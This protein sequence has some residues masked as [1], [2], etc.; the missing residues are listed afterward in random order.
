M[1]IEVLPDDLAV[2]IAG[3]RTTSSPDPMQD[4]RSLRR[5]CKWMLQV[6]KNREVAKCILVQWALE[7]EVFAVPEYNGDYR[8]YLIANLAEAGNIEAC[9]RDGL[10]VI[11]DVN[12]RELNCLLDNLEST[13]NKRHN[14]AA[15][16]LAMCLYRRNGGDG[17]DEKAKELLRKLKVQDGPRV[18]AAGG[19][20]VPPRWSN[21]A[22][23]VARLQTTLH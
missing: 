12:R 1:A 23:V 4:L 10:R 19:I 3:C 7:R 8:E 16:M 11:F 13:A 5:S 21:H 6:C 18:A 14:L 9:F 15:Y 2:A 20:G 17:D 22:F